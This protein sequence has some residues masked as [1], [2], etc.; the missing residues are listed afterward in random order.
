M[1]LKELPDLETA[2]GGKMSC[3]E[4]GCKTTY[5]YDGSDYL[6]QCPNCCLIFDAYYELNMET[7]D[8]LLEDLQDGTLIR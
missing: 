6:E 5:P 1:Q 7:E 4:C 2:K 3:P 8:E